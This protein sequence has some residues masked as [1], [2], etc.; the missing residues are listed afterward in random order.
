MAV[1]TAAA[2]PGRLASAAA[3]YSHRHHSFGRQAQPDLRLESVA[4]PTLAFAGERFPIDIVVTSP[5]RTSAEVSFS[6][7]GQ[8]LGSTPVTL[9]QGSYRL[10]VHTS[11]TK[12][13]T[14]DLSG[15]I[16]APQIGEVR[17]SR[18][19][20]LRRPRA[21]LVSQDPARRR[22]RSGEDTHRRSVRDPE[23]GCDSGR[24]L[25]LPDRGAQ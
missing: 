22:C 21:L 20:S 6:T 10:W 15:V 9:E 24:S 8:L 12:V 16:R 7:E 14:M 23:G 4:T 18:A 1:R 17:F 25:R 2:P 13:G 11:I 19:L 3:W 5:R